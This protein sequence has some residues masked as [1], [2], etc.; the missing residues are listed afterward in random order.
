MCNNVFAGILQLLQMELMFSKFKYL[1]L[2]KRAWIN[3]IQ[4]PANSFQPHKTILHII[5][6]YC[7]RINTNNVG[8][9]QHSED[10]P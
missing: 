4:V 7:T 8:M 1:V 6:S 9:S 2:Y 3:F 5:I 10:T